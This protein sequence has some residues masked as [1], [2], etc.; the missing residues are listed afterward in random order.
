MEKQ[1][2]KCKETKLLINFDAVPKGQSKDGHRG[3]CISC[4]NLARNIRNATKN[5]KPNPNI[6]S[7]HCWR[8]DSTKI[9]EEFNL[10]KT[11][12][13]GYSRICRPCASLKNKARY[14]KNSDRIK[15]RTNE[16]YRQNKPAVI[17][18]A[19]ITQKIKTKT[20]HLYTFK[21][22]ISRQIW[23]Q[24][25]KI[26]S[27]KNEKTMKILGTNEE[28]LRQYIDN[29][30]APGTT[31]NDYHIDHIVPLDMARNEEQIK[32]LNYYKNLRLI[33]AKENLSKGALPPTNWQKLL[34][35]LTYDIDI[36]NGYPEIGQSNLD[37]YIFQ[38]ES[39]SSEHRSFIE[40]YEW[41]GNVGYRY[42][43]VYTARWN[44]KLAAVMILGSPN[45]I[46]NNENIYI[47]RGASASWVAKNL[48]T[49]ML[50]SLI[51]YLKINTNYKVVRGYADPEANERGTLY[52]AANFKQLDGFFGTKELFKLG[53]RYVGSQYFNKTS[54]YKR[55]AK[56]N[57][58]K[59]EKDWCG[60]NGYK[61]ISKIPLELKTLVKNLRK[62][63]LKI[64][65]TRKLKFE[66]KL[67]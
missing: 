66:Y 23:G 10:C 61:I 52:K 34:K 37:D 25:K 50:S 5:N 29:Q 32:I 19:R 38:I 33:P 44:D 14:L 18:S 17:A 11:E 59:W 53:D 56:E 9:V 65:A 24:F 16:Y 57:N 60:N 26:D 45:Y 55:I 28:T 20:N 64:K 31:I 39:F 43:L 58:I 67:K 41:L 7:I 62:S 27:S 1:C 6:K 2:S 46:N 51:T 4:R 8:C 30:I 54:T 12:P 63:C 35:D 48:G 49:K 15:Q 22:R 47:H 13:S 36:A 3:V 21:R 40:R 42:D